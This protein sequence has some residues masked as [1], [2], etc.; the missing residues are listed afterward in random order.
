MYMC[1]YVCAYI[2]IHIYTLQV[3]LSKASWP[4]VKG[5][6]LAVIEKRD[7]KLEFPTKKE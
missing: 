2:Y 6:D 5:K 4:L 1:V 3:N 7:N